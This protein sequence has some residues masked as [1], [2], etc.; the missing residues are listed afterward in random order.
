MRTYQNRFWCV[1]ICLRRPDVTSLLSSVSYLGKAFPDFLVGE[2][3]R[4]HIDVLLIRL[5]GQETALIE[6]RQ[7]SLIA[8]EI[9][10]EVNRSVC[11]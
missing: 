7:R 10:V 9:L 5:D 2:A 11:S 1:L 6:H 8:V 3:Q 4:V